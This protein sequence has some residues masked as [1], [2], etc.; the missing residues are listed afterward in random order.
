MSGEEELQLVEAAAF[1]YA[2]KMG[3]TMRDAEQVSTHVARRLRKATEYAVT[4]AG[5]SPEK[6]Q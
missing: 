6:Y 2:R 1:R 5:F 4:D 3:A